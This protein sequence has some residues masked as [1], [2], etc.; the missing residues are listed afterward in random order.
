MAFM[1]TGQISPFNQRRDS[2]KAQAPEARN[3]VIHLDLFNSLHELCLH[4][5][6]SAWER[7]EKRQGKEKLTLPPG[8][9][10]D[11]MDMEQGKNQGERDS[12]MERGDN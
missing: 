2:G 3:G 6:R 8:I 10:S 5:E 7:G 12:S 1:A 11:E 4:I 9:F